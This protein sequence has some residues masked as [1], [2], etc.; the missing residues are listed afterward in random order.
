MAWK[1]W[2]SDS[3]WRMAGKAFVSC[4]HCP[5]SWVY[6]GR[7]Q[8]VPQC[9]RCHAPWPASYGEGKPKGHAIVALSRH[10]ETPSKTGSWG[11]VSP[12]RV[13]ARNK[14]LPS[15]SATSTRCGKGQGVGVFAQALGGCLRCALSSPVVKQAS[16][17][18]AA[19]A[20]P[21]LILP[22][23]LANP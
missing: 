11:R 1:T 6:N 16:A 8:Q 18:W 19:W 15:V 2:A 7:L 20:I 13:K 14:P 4:Q 5:G 23:L 3:G 22:L 12:A 9:K 17:C 21:S 10:W